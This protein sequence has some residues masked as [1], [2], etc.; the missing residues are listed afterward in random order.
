M[1]AHLT[2]IGTF[3]RT[4]IVAHYLLD[5]GQ[6]ARPRQWIKNLACFA[7]LVF[8]GHLFD[9][10]A[11]FQSVLAFMGFC[12][13]RRPCTCSTMSWTGGSIA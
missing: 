13:P 12:L 7:G 8:S 9:P 11:M 2:A 1:D 4:A 10:R 6:A 3:P 5:L